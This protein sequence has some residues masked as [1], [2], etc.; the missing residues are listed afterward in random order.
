MGKLLFL[1]PWIYTTTT[2]YEIEL[3]FNLPSIIHNGQTLA[4]TAKRPGM[5]WDS[6]AW[7]RQV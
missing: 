1:S 7:I 3:L 6:S 5:R 4:D 2:D